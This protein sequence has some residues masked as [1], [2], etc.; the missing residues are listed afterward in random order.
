MPMGQSAQ[1]PITAADLLP[2]TASPAITPPPP[3]A[4]GMVA[5]PGGTPL[6]G[7][8]SPDAP[9]EPPYLVELQ[10]DGS[11]VYKTKTNPSVVIGVNKAPKLPPAMQPPKQ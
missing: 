9:A 6:A 2:P 10:A 5:G 3:Q 11:S 4:Q 7:F 1:L 8:P